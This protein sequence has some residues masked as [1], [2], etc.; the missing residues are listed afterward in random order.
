MPMIKII[1]LGNV[2]GLPEEAD[3]VEVTKQ[4]LVVKYQTKQ[5]GRGGGTVDHTMNIPIASAVY[6]VTTVVAPE[7]QD[8]DDAPV[9]VPKRRGRPPKAQE[10]EPEAPRR[11]GRPP[12][13]KEPEVEEEDADEDDTPAPAPKRRGRPPKVKDPEPEV[14]EDDED[15]EPE[16]PRRR[17][18]PPKAKDDEPAPR[19]RRAAPVEPEDDEEFTDDFKPQRAKADDDDE[20][21]P[22]KRRQRPE[23]PKVKVGAAR[24]PFAVSDGGQDWPDDM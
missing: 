7:A 9:T 12:K 19:K 16:P 24:K 1:P 2:K 14:E 3:L 5:R 10:A 20:P 22:R 17:G 21:A 11:R 6:E 13:A 8:E 15:A 23:E 18:R 4:H